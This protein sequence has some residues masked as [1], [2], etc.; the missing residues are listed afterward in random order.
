MLALQPLR[1]ALKHARALPQEGAS[2]DSEL[3]K[4]IAS[5]RPLQLV[6]PEEQS[7]WAEESP[8]LADEALPTRVLPQRT[9]L[10]ELAF[11][12]RT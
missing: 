1:E 4:P 12:V 2:V 11:G 9:E 10:Q 6:Q 8:P 7:F 3:P 5:A